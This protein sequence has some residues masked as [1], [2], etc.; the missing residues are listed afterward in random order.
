[1]FLSGHCVLVTV[2]NEYKLF[3]RSKDDGAIINT[4]I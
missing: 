2:L 3:P 1:M 4:T